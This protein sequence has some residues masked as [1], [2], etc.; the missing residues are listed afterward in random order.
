VD[1]YCVK[2]KTKRDLPEGTGVITLANGRPAMQAPCPVCGTKL[3]RI[4]GME[5]AKEK[6]WTP[7]A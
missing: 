2:C 6:G 1:A 4:L 5:A 3:N 7:P